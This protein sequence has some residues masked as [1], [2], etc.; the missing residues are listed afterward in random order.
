MARLPA[1]QESNKASKKCSADYRWVDHDEDLYSSLRAVSYYENS[2]SDSV[3]L[4]S[5]ASIRK[6]SKI[7]KIL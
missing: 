1:V 7:S 5:G 2:T 6:L 3:A 4:L